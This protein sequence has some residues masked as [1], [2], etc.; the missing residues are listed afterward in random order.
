MLAITNM[1][2]S[3]IVELLLK[4]HPDLNIQNLEKKTALDLAQE[5]LDKNPEDDSSITI[6]GLLLSC[7]ATTG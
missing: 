4:Y 7:T 1:C 5:R 6:V 3:K 2:D